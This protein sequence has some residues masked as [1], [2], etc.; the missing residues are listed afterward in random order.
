LPALARVRLLPQPQL[1]RNRIEMLAHH[2]VILRDKF[3]LTPAESRLALRLVSGES[4]QTAASALDIT[5]ETA[6][7]VLKNIFAKTGTDRQ[8]QLVGVILSATVFPLGT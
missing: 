5:Y 8:T 1:R 2:T 7:T 4:L 6:R 3:G